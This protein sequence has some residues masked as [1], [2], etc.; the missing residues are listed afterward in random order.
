MIYEKLFSKKLGVE[1]NTIK[2]MRE[3]I[4]LKEKLA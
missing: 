2:I 3:N 4:K 1:L